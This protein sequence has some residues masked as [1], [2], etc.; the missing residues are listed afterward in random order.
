MRWSM[1]GT[2][3]ST[4]A[5]CFWTVLRVPFGSNLRWVIVVDPIA[6][7]SRNC[8]SPVPWNSGAPNTVRSF[9]LSGT[10]SRNWAAANG[11][12]TCR[13]A[14]FGV[15]VV[16]LVSSTRPPTDLGLADVVT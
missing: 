13:G 14:P 7:V 8:E 4:S 15:P 1:V 3:T 9:S 12:L 10:R 11:E 16:P 2:R 6:R 5:L